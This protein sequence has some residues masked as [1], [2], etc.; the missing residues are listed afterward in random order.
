[1]NNKFGG[2]PSEKYLSKFKKF[3]AAGFYN[4]LT[5]LTMSF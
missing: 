3:K 5:Y 4:V 2:Y 1:M